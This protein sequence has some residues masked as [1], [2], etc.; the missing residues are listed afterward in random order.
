MEVKSYT[1]TYDGLGAIP[2]QDGPD[3]LSAEKPAVNKNIQPNRKQRRADKARARKLAG[4]IARQ[5]RRLQIYA[6]RKDA[7]VP[8]VP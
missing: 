6:A 1:G 2:G 7:D 8:R 4:E 5:E 3:G